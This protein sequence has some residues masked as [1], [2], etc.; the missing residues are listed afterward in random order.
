MNKF[1]NFISTIVL[2]LVLQLTSWSKCCCGF[3]VVSPPSSSYYRST[4]TNT[5]LKVTLEGRLIEGELKPTNNFILIKV[6]DAIEQTDGGIILAGKSK[7]V[8]TQGFV[9]A[10]GPGK[11]HQE[12]GLLFPMPVA[13]GD[14]VVYGKYD[15][16]EV[17][18]DG[19]KCTLIRDSD[20]L[21]KYAAPNLTLQDVRV[22]DDSVLVK[23]NREAEETTAGGLLIAATSKKKQKTQHGHRGQNWTRTHGVQR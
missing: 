12:S 15:G 16:T 2:L 7:V 11:T 19:D 14:G 22:C 9:L 5:H 21:V 1:S 6:D 3:V 10:V 17:E 4:A 18:Y 20:V 23:V 8:K 13:V